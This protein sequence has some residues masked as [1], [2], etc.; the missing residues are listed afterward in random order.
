MT[1]SDCGQHL[2][3]CKCEDAAEKLLALRDDPSNTRPVKWCMHC[4]RFWS[5]CRCGFLRQQPRF[6]FFVKGQ[7]VAEQE[8]HGLRKQRT[9]IPWRINPE[10][11]IKPD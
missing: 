8:I 6:Q 1:C 4:N 7:A 2:A 11:E 3:S 10:R 5:R 9:A